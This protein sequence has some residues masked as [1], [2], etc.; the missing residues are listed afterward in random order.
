MDADNPIARVP[1]SD[2]RRVIV[3]VSMIRD[4]MEHMEDPE[5]GSCA[6]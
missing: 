6:S 5:M 2:M 4:S 3:T 1:L